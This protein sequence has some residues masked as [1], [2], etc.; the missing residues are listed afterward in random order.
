[1]LTRLLNGE[2]QPVQV[3]FAGKAHP[4]DEAGKD[5]IR[6]V[7]HY[8]QQPGLKGRVM[9]LED[10]A[11]DDARA[12]VRGVDVWLNNPRRPLEASGTSGQKASLNGALNASVVDGWWVEGYNGSNGWQIGDATRVYDSTEA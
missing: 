10:Y 3:I 12:L 8:M 5:L 7:I 4:A 11:I 2:G 6:A 9:F 1:R